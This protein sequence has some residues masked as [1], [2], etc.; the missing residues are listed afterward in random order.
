MRLFVRFSNTVSLTDSITR[1][2]RIIKNAML[3]CLALLAPPPSHYPL[4][5]PSSLINLHNL[6]W[7]L[8]ALYDNLFCAIRTLPICFDLS[9]TLNSDTWESALCQKFGILSEF[10]LESVEQEH[11]GKCA[12]E[13]WWFLRIAV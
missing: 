8:E 12:K 11:A 13:I 1:N 10:S 2:K 4:S 9:I 5:K 3:W 7:C 6:K